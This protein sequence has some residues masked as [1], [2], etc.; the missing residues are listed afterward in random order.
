MNSSVAVQ[1]KAVCKLDD[2]LPGTG[3]GVRLPGRQSALF[4]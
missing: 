2:V 1:W 3:V 4:R